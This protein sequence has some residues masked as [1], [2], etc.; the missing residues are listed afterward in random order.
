MALCRNNGSII[1]N[2]EYH[3]PSQLK[4][5]Q[6]FFFFFFL[7]TNTTPTPLVSTQRDDADSIQ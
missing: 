5:L 4:N 6:P 2:K 7:H 3:L 1:F